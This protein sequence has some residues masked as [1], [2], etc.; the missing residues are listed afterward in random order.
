MTQLQI[1]FEGPA[2]PEVKLVTKKDKAVDVTFIT[3]VGGDYKIH[4]KYKDNYIHGSP[5][6]CKV[7]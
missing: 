1:G 4:V 2:Q 5:Y 3:A 6:K 7:K